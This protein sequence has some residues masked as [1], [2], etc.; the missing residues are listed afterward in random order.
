M[1]MALAGSRTLCRASLCPAA[2]L[3]WR[4]TAK[5]RAK[6]NR[7][8]RGSRTARSPT[9]P[10]PTP[11]AAPAPRPAEAA[12]FW[13]RRPLRRWS[14]KRWGWRCP[15][16][17]WRLPDMPSGRHGAAF[18]PRRAGDGSARPDDAR[19][20]DRRRGAQRDGGARG[21]RRIHESHPAPARH[22]ARR[23]ACAA[24]GGRLDAR[25]SRRRRG[26]WTRCPTAQ[27]LSHGAGLSGG[28][29]SGSDAASAARGVCSR[30]ARH[31]HGRNA[32]RGARLV[33][34]IRAPRGAARVLQERDGIDPDDVIMAPDVARRARPDFH[35]H[36]SE[37]QSG[38]GR[39][40]HQEHLDR[41][42]RGGRRRR[43]SQDRPGAGL[44]H[45]R[46]SAIAAIK[47]GR[48]PP[49]RRAGADVPRADGLGHGRDLPDHLGAAL[50]GFRKARRGDYG[51][52]LQWRLDRRVHRARR[53]PKPW[54]A[55]RSAR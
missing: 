24:H 19:R 42:E 40:R 22:R 12:S 23:R 52:A 49:G 33:G 43:L 2:S 50:S 36:V 31:R 47:G 3:C 29:R 30:P 15:T 20:P 35:R 7:W 9:R 5:T 46:R 44:S 11:C 34:A 48:D 26:W 8:A 41:P 55:A 28:R 6:C 51:R 4:K 37:G 27:M 21:V 14:A 13:G 25:Q 53:L 16:R 17:R 38:A 10:L 32:G 18:G 1:M 54:R 45:A 39:L